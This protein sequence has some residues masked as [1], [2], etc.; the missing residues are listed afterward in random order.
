MSAA[1]SWSSCDT[2]PNDWLGHTLMSVARG[3]HVHLT[4][5]TLESNYVRDEV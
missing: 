5:H 3:R 1:G 4:D 2:Y